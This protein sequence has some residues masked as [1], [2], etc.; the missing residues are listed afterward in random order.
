M[1][2]ILTDLGGGFV[3]QDAEDGEISIYMGYCLA[4]T[5]PV[6]VNDVSW[7]L[8]HSPVKVTVDFCSGKRETVRFNKNMGALFAHNFIR[9]T[10]MRGFQ[11]IDIPGAGHLSG[12][13]PKG[14]DN[15]YLVSQKD[16]SIVKVIL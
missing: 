1:R 16:G 5:S 11:T 6:S 13:T 12:A 10:L 9:G 8:V 15:T 4:G 14:A 7:P 2:S 3:R